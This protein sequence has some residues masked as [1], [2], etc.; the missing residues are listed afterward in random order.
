MATIYYTAASVDGF[1]AAD[2]HD[3]SWLLQFDTAEAPGYEEFIASV[4]ALA[5]GASTYLWVAEHLATS[6]SGEPQPWPYQQPAWV[7]THRE[8]PRIPGADLRF[9]QGDVRPVHAEMVRVAAGRD[10][11]IVGGGDLAGQFAD[12]GLLDELVLTLA[13]VTLGSGMPLLPRRISSPPL[14]LRSARQAGPFA[15]LRY[16]LPNP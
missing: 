2:G 10:I 12:H 7:F 6:Q 16:R 9:V 11:W 3:L 14:E 4:G 1:I 13:P 15:E 8:L 5:M